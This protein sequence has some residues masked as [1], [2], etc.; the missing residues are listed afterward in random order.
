VA[1]ATDHC[2]IHECLTL[3]SDPSSFHPSPGDNAFAWI[4]GKIALRLA[5]LGM[6]SLGLGVV[7]ILRLHAASSLVSDITNSPSGQDHSAQLLFVLL[8]FCVIHPALY[9]AVIYIRGVLINITSYNE[10]GRGFFDSLLSRPYHIIRRHSSGEIL[11]YSNDFPG[12]IIALGIVCLSDV[13]Y[14]LAFIAMLAFVLL[15][16]SGLL[17]LPVVFWV[18][19]L[20]L[21][22]AINFRSMNQIAAAAMQS[23]AALSGTKSDLLDNFALIK[24]SHGD[25]FHL[26]HV[27]ARFDDVLDKGTQVSRRT[28][29][30]LGMVNLINGVTLGLGIAVL[31]YLHSLGE[32]DIAMFVLFIPVMLQLAAISQ[33]AMEAINSALISAGKLGRIRSVLA[34]D[35]TGTKTDHLETGVVEAKG[36]SLRHAEAETYVLERASFRFERG[37]RIGISAPSGRG[38]ST[39]LLAIADLLRVQ[40][41]QLRA[42]TAD[43]R[44]AICTQEPLMFNASIEDNLCYGAAHDARN[45]LAQVLECVELAREIEAAGGLGQTIA[46]R[47]NNLSGGQKQR[48]ALARALLSDPHILILDEALSGVDEAQEDRILAM[49]DQQFPDI[50]LIVASHRSASLARC[51]AR[52]TIKEQ[53]L[54]LLEGSA[55]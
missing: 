53:K 13:G 3:P 16:T 37:A 30:L 44:T 14:F 38:K 27:T 48:L 1:N 34:G 55:E 17:L 5:S 6:V 22:G 10:I 25:D 33:I 15:K 23:S 35:H 36:I 19:A 32:A 20:V 41:G 8:L 12:S 45:R 52:Y 24:T 31:Y 9:V 50:T 28:S 7:E 18:L 21:L 40:E 51:T 42:G 4:K 11:N 46:P 43:D 2:R 29:I 54:V 49:L 39:L 47:G 26:R